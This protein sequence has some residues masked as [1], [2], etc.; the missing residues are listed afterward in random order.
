MTEIK[1]ILFMSYLLT[2][3]LDIKQKVGFHFQLKFDF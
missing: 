2:Q 1:S 3:E